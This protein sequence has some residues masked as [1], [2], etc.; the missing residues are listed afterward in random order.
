VDY[1]ADALFWDHLSAST[2]S[3]K[4]IHSDNDDGTVETKPFSSFD[5][6]VKSQ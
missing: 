2:G 5:A 1:G 3:D 6:F 4:N